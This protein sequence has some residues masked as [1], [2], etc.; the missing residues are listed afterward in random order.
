M[1]PRRQAKNPH[2]EAEQFRRR[3]VL[4]FGVV[5]LCLLGLGGWYFKLQVL[6]H[7]VYATRSEANRIK[8]RPV[9]PGR[10]MIYD[11]NGRLLA[12]NVPAFRLDVTP[13]KVADMDAML[14]ALGKVIP[15]A[16]EDLDRFNRER[17]ARRSFLPVTLR[18]RMSDEEMARFAL[19]RW[20]FPGVELEPYLTRRYPYGELFAHIIGYVGRIDEK[21][22]AALGEGNAALTHMGKSG[23]ERYYEQDLRG[24]VGYEQVETNVQGR[25]IRTVG[26]VPAQS[27]ADLRL[28]VDADLQRAMVAAFGEFEG[29]AI[30]MDPRTGEILGMV[31]LPSYDPNLFVNGISHADFKALNDNPSRPQ[32]NRLV[33][34]G[35][36]PGSTLKPLLALAGLDSGIRRPEDRILSTGM[37]YLPGTRRG[38]GDS[39]RGGH[40]WT[41]LRKSIAQSVN[42]Y[43]YRLALDMGIGRIDRYLHYY[44]LGQPTGVDLLGEIGGILPSPE[45]KLKSRKERWYPG[46]TV[47]MSIGQGDWKVT[48]MQLVR[49]I[50]GIADGQLRRPHLVVQKRTGFDHPWQPLPQPAG[51]PISPNPNNLQVVREGMKDTMRPGGTG[52]AITGGAP[53]QMAG[54]TGTAQVVSRKG[55]AAVNPRNL[56]LHLRHRGLFVGFAPADNPTIVLA[57]AVE[58]GGFGTSSAAPIAR[59]IFDAWLLGKLPSGVEPLDSELGSTAVGLVQFDAASQDVRAAGD[60]AALE[61]PALPVMLGQAPIAPSPPPQVPPVGSGS[62]AT[63]ATPTS[64]EDEP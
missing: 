16:P 52:Y 24:K 44:G 50:G 30:A 48:P 35:V 63:P 49:G 51:K 4:G 40:G 56:P 15:I 60:Q 21:D 58:G 39:H 6:D 12:E 33:L 31:S 2:A 28:S 64:T 22:L 13:D 29:A 25:A 23:L 38:W 57:V 41:D 11:R 32:F 46:D 45:Y 43:Y 54:K 5:M 10:G 27:G 61:L 26:R 8:P 18:L 42:T 36:A 55:V 53:Y 47:N 37:F 20:R 3:A 14:A 34:G 7:E 59:K 1:Y 19:E 62:A 9:V 17:K